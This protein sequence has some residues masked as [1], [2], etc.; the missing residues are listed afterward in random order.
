M[1]KKIYERT[2]Y[3]NI[4]RHKKNKNYIIMVS[5]PV[6]TSISRIDNKKI[7]S[8]E[9]AIRIRDNYFKKAGK[10]DSKRFTN[11]LDDLWNKY[12]FDCEYVDKLA[13]N[14]LLSKKKIYNKY[15][16]NKV[17]VNIHKTTKTFWIDFINEIKTTS[18]QKNTI[19]KQLKALFNWAISN[20]YI[21]YNAVDKI[22]FFETNKEEIEVWEEQDLIKF[23]EYLNNELPKLNSHQKNIIFIIKIFTYIGFCYGLRPG[24]IRALTFNSFNTKNLTLSIK[25]SINYDKKGEFLARTKTKKSNRDIIINSQ[26]IDMIK[27]YRIFLENELKLN[28]NDDNIIIFNYSTMRPY[29]SETIRSY[30]YNY[31]IKANVKK[32]KIY[33]LRHSYATNM[34]LYDVPIKYVSDNMGHTSIKITGD[35]YSHILDKKRKEIAEITDKLFF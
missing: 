4:Y 1:D 22:R 14:T 3:Q 21:N 23:I 30:F 7:I 9:D 20:E 10:G 16:K 17:K 15:L 5:K 34:L 24:E 8:I 18:K 13:Y 25:H 27:D 31:S 29:C 32:I 12:I 26:I 28:I 2:R 6:K 19:L 11:N 35:V 33:N